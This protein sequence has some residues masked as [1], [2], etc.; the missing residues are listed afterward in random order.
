MDKFKEFM[1][2]IFSTSVKKSTINDKIISG[3]Y[4][5]ERIRKTKTYWRNYVHPEVSKI[6]V[7]I[8][9]KERLE[10]IRKEE[11]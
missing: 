5:R 9:A 2:G 7:K 1:K 10:D 11:E 4:V 8:N 6:L 3:T